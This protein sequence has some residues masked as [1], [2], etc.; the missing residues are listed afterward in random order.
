MSASTCCS[1]MNNSINNKG[2]ATNSNTNNECCSTCNSNTSNTAQPTQQQQQQHHHERRPPR[3]PTAV[4]SLNPRQ[5]ERLRSVLDQEVQIHGRENFPTLEIPLHTLIVN[6]RRKLREAGLPVRHVKVNGGAASFVF[7]SSDSF[8]YSDIDL[9]FP[10]DLP[11]DQDFERVRESVFAALLEMM[12]STTNKQLITT[13]T[14]RDV[15]IRKMVKVTDGQDRWSL[16]S[17]HNDY[18]RCIEL[19]F[20][21]RMRRQFEFSV[22]SFQITLDPLIDRP[23]DARPVVRAESMYGD[24]LQALYH[25]NKR[26][27]DTRNPEEIRG[28]GLLKYCHLLTRE[29]SATANCRDMEKYMCSRFFIDFPDINVQEMKLLNYLQNHFGNE[30]ELKLDYL[31]RLLC[32][33]K[34]STVCLMY[35]ERRQTLAMVRNAIQCHAN[36]DRL[37]QQ[38]SYNMYMYYPQHLSATAPPVNAYSNGGHYGGKQRRY[39][40]HNGNY[41][42]HRNWQPNN[43]RNGNGNFNSRN[44]G[45]ATAGHLLSPVAAPFSSPTAVAPSS[46]SSASSGLSAVAEEQQRHATPM[47]SPMVAD[48]EQKR[49]V[50]ASE[51]AIG[52]EVAGVEV[53]SSVTSSSQKQSPPAAATASA[54]VP[55]QTLLY[56]PPNANQWIPVV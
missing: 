29:Y 44:V 37:R 15:Y 27:I 35:H 51:A 30:D 20:V 7:A 54:H 38:L 16:F 52:A 2:S 50:A 39:S 41:H 45:T 14:L 28:G 31:Q 23:T 8:P 10:L 40:S 6:V 1:K 3:Q 11:T 26:L 46:S 17:L 12:P 13:D 49:A 25:L 33:I 34:E 55:R 22:D 18:G 9:I 47:P 21:E 48:D 36:V 56:L 32:V 43:Y 4:V 24:F 19:K 53:P 5:M 42:Q